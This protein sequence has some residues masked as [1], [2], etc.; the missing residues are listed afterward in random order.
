MA[1][2]LTKNVANE[3]LRRIK[4]GEISPSTLN[5]MSP[6]EMHAYFAEFMGEANAKQ[7]TALFE[8]KMRANATTKTYV[9]TVKKITGLTPEVRE[10]IISKLQKMG[11]LLNPETEKA[12]MK[13][14]VEKKL[15]ATVSLEDAQKITEIS[16]EAQKLKEELAAD[17]TNKEKQIA[18]G[19]KVMDAQD[20]VDSL[21]KKQNPFTIT[22]ILNL[23]KTMLTSVVHFSAP[24]VQGVFSIGT[25]PFWQATAAQFKYFASPRAYRDAQ[26]AIIAHPDYDISQKAGLS[27]THLGDKLTTREE[28]I[29]SSLLEHIPGIRVPVKAFS[30]A[31]T[32]FLND[33]RFRNYTQLLTAARNANEDVTPGSKVTK[34]LARVVNDMTGR[35]AIGINDSGKSFVPILNAA[36][37]SPRKISATLGM[38]N[39][40]NYVNPRISPTA[41][42]ARLKSLISYL[43]A[44]GAI[45][46]L[47]KFSKF[48]VDLN[49]IS[50]DFGD[51]SIGNTKFNP[52]G[53]SSQIIKLISRLV[54]NKEQSASGKTG[55]LGAPIYTTSKTGKLEKT[56]YTNIT[57]AGE[58][59]DY[60]RNHLSP[61]AGALV[62]WLAG[63]N[64]V[65]QPVTFNPAA[66]TKSEEYN[67]FVPLVIQDFIN[68]AV[69]DP[70]NTIAWLPSL[71]AIFGVSMQSKAPVTK[72]TK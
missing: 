48:K 37:F 9:N 42:Q 60:A 47:A 46:G 18:Y 22:N 72:K 7:V 58:V 54:T 38:L 14:L 20:L 29:Q 13:D 56:P 49:P 15:G 32:G 11:D 24:F 67:L 27:L 3:F 61:V 2:C 43:V 23:P 16:N 34:D 1:F 31:F 71:S 21:K 64:A 41:R 66:G 52:T 28:A 25:K 44:M 12:F 51:V 39:P 45:Y 33:V 35:G 36:F 40:V 59:A 57:K 62:D 10:N 5:E 26:A 6:D 53:G 63:T 8:E 55:E 50:T 70:H 68:L 19:N 17:P 4:E 65:G 69:N 30:R